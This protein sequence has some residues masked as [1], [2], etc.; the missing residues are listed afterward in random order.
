[1]LLLHGG[2]ALLLLRPTAQQP[3]RDASRNVLRLIALPPVSQPARAPSPPATTAAPPRA[4]ASPN[5]I[6]LPALPRA[7]DD[8]APPVSPAPTTAA[9]PASEP[10]PLDLRLP[11]RVAT[12][13][14]PSLADQIRADP[15]A[16]S[17][18]SSLDQQLAAAMGAGEIEVINDVQGGRMI[19]GPNG[20]C[21]LIRP[22]MMQSVDPSDE[23]WRQLPGK[24]SDCSRLQ[25]GARRHQRPP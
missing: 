14:A 19:R 4:I 2:A 12:P 20:E 7:A 13:T 3:A 25:P 6:T 9:A 21:T 11:A 1:M 22:S 17:P 24:V 15:R 8:V 16:N 18:R 10:A 5:A 23:R